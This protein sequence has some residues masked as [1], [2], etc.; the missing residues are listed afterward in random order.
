MKED[1]EETKRRERKKK[2]HTVPWLC[3]PGFRCETRKEESASVNRVSLEPESGGLVSGAGL[4][5][6]SCAASDTHL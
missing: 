4:P 2:Q 3:A 5:L 1:K 6:T